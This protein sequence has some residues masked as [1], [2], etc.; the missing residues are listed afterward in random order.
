[1]RQQSLSKPLN[2]V[3]ETGR[4]DWWDRTALSVV[5]VGRGGVLL[6]SGS[7]L[8]LIADAER[9]LTPDGAVLPDPIDFAAV[10]SAALIA[11][12]TEHRLSLGA[13]RGLPPESVHRQSL[14]LETEP[15]AAGVLAL[16]HAIGELPVLTTGLRP[17]PI[18]ALG[19]V[20][21]E[22][23][24]NGD[25]QIVRAALTALIGAGPGATPTG[26][27]VVVGILAGFH[28]LARTDPN[29]ADASRAIAADLAP[30]LPRTTRP[31]GQEL[32][33]AADGRFSTRL[34]RLVAATADPA[35]AGH[36]ALAASRWGATSGR[37]LASGLISALRASRLG[38]LTVFPGRRSA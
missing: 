29:S 22:A 34:H 38:D 14:R 27:D 33:A 31:S 7:D 19:P 16:E 23:A 28:A 3:V 32:A 20:L 15:T 1:V 8:H 5:H 30:L 24:L 25:R 21:A 26:D 36:V 35:A 12:R 10:R 6:D 4:A 13:W 18:R 9:G 17:A 2:L 37:D 11:E